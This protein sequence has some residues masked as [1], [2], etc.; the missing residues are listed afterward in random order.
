MKVLM[1]HIYELNKGV[2]QMVLF[3]CNKKYGAQTVSQLESQG[4]PYLLQS[5]GR[6]NLNVYFGRPECLEA[7]RLIRERLGVA[8]ILGVSNVSFG[9]PR[10]EVLNAAFLTLALGAGLSAGIVNPNNA[11][12]M[13]AIRVFRALRGDDPGFETYIRTHPPIPADASGLRWRTPSGSAKTANPV[14]TFI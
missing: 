6:Q 10:R 11:A 2:R 12:L 7:I 4:I 14:H 9:L 1:T 8:T 5:A 3:T 13:D